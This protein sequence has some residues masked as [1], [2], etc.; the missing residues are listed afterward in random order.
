MVGLGNPG[1]EYAWSRHNAGWLVLDS[2]VAKIG[3]GEPRMKFGGAFWSA[4]SL[5]NGSV[6]FL[7]PFTYMNLSGTAVSESSRYYGIAPADVYVISDDAAIPFG[8]LRF[9]RAGSAGGHKGLASIIGA[10][11]TLDVPR[12]RIGVGAPPG[13]A[14]MRGWVLGR[15]AKEQREAWPGV[16]DAAWTALVKWLRGE[17]GPGFTLGITAPK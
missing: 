15:F 3:L 14:D 6:A 17:S 11:G 16:D 8:K 1:P 4:V 13:T 7:K 5:E 2:I 9:R 12:L 10:L